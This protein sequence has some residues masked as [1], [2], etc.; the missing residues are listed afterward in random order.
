MFYFIKRDGGQVALNE[1][2][3][4]SKSLGEFSLATSSGAI[5]GS[6]E[7]SSPTRGSLSNGCSSSSTGTPTSTLSRNNSG[8]MSFSIGLSKR[9]PSNNSLRMTSRMNSRDNLF[10]EN[11]A[12]AG[13]GDDDL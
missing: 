11:S 2:I 13:I 10:M 4:I 7:S 8:D 5:N 9:R 1:D 6:S 12:F 3:L